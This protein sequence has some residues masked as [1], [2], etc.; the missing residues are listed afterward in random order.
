MINCKFDTT[1]HKFEAEF[2]DGT[3]VTGSY[4]VESGP[5]LN[6]SMEL[7]VVYTC[8]NDAHSLYT[9]KLDVLSEK[10]LREVRFC[11]SDHFPTNTPLFF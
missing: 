8:D 7:T 2:P 11:L 9:R 10:I 5:I 4:T 3:L 1:T 6:D